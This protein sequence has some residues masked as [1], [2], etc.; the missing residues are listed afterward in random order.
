MGGKKRKIYGIPA[1]G[2][3]KS[4]DEGMRRAKRREFK[5]VPKRKI[6]EMAQH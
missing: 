4:K 1:D 6:L 5:K 2:K 3:K